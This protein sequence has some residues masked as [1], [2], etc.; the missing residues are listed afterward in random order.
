MIPNKAEKDFEKFYDAL[1]RTHKEL[2]K[3][4]KLLGWWKENLRRFYKKGYGYAKGGK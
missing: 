2:L 3:N 4:E 1:L